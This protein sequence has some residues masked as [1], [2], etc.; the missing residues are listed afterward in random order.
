MPTREERRWQHF[1]ANKQMHAVRKK[2]KRNRKD[3]RVRRKEW[4][5]ENLDDLDALDAL[6]QI[7]R[8]VPLG[9][10]ERR[11]SMMSAALA[12]LQEDR[13]CEDETPP[14]PQPP[15]QSGVVVEVS[16]GLCR[17]DVN[18]RSQ[19]CSLRG[20]L[21][22]EDTGLTN[23]VAVGDDVMVSSNGTDRGVVEAVLPRRSALVR[24]DVFRSHL[25]QVIVANAEQLLVVASWREPAIWFELV[26][27]YLIAAQRNGLA[28]LICVNKIDLVQD[29]AACQRAL[30]PHRDLGFRVLFTSALTGQGV[31]ELRDVLHGNTTVL[32]GLSGV[33]KSS[34]LTA[35]Q[36]DLDLRTGRV[37]DQSNEGRHV[38]TQATMLRLKGGGYVVDTPGIREFGLGGL[39]Q[40]E[41]VQYFPEICALQPQCRFSNCLHIHEPGCAVQMAVQDGAVA[42]TRYHSYVK[43]HR[44]LAS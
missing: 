19:L 26:D 10:R 20:S 6:P 15:G 32:A 8:V 38:T 25:S 37:S 21:S 1:E 14:S 42:A 43:I 35:V 31:D 44:D 40:G 22:A 29:M 13:S 36:P 30:Q 4:I 34:L 27:R 16:S 28:P 24:P 39:H 33:G 12:S 7:E 41:L 23:V 11:E 17:V 9:E 3:K 2:I 5:P 18:G